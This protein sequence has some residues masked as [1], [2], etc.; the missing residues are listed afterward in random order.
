MGRDSNKQPFSW[1]PR[2]K[3]RTLGD[4][5]QRGTCDGARS[6]GGVGPG[7]SQ[8]DWE[9][10]PKLPKWPPLPGE[11]RFAPGDVT[12]ETAAAGQQT[13]PPWN[14]GG[15]GR[16]GGTVWRRFQGLSRRA[17]VGVIVAAVALIALVCT[18]ASVA[19]LG[20]ALLNPTAGSARNT[21]AGLTSGQKVLATSTASASPTATAASQTPT[22]S[23]FTITFTCA[24]GSIGGTGQVCIHTQPNANVS[25]TVRYCDGNY[26]TGK[27]LRGSAHTDGSGNYTWRWRVS[28]HCAGDATA[29]ITAKSGG[30]TVTERTT[31]T[32]TR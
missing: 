15:S 1:I 17:R 23:S 14:Q 2:P 4:A 16:S 26:A 31:F 25:L 29:T 30:Q 7:A 10:L 18:L 20:G 6:D 11:D 3:P 21:P 28:T 19:A 32:I 9:Q 8:V 12:V 27:S 24:S 5:I 22:P 13:P